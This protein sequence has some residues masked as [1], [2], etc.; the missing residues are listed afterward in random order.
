M[1]Q[2][3]P[4][5]SLVSMIDTPNYVCNS[6]HTLNIAI[7][8]SQSLVNKKAILGAFI[9]NH[10]PD[11]IIIS[12]TWLSSDISTAEIFP[13]GYNVFRRDRQG[14]HGGVLLATRTSL[15]CH[16]LTFN[17][18]IEA[19]S[20]K[21]TLKNNQSLIVCSVYRPPDRNLESMESLCQLFESLCSTHPDSP[22]WIAGD[23]N[24]PNIDWESFCITNSSYPANLCEILINFTLEHGFTQ[25]VNSPTRGK[26]ILDIF[27]TNRVSLV[28]HCST[29]AG[30]SDHEA[31]LV[32]SSL[33][34]NLEPP[35]HKI[36]LWPL[37]NI[38]SMKELASVL[39]Q[40]FLEKNSPS[41]NIEV[42][43]REFK[44]ICSECM[45]NVPSKLSNFKNR[46]QPWISHHIQQLSRKKQRLYNLAKSSQSPD[47]WQNYYKLKKEM[48]KSCRV[49]YND[50]VA[51]LVEDDHITKRLWTFIK[52]QRKDNCNIPP[53]Q[54]EG[55][56]YT[57]H[58]QKAEIFNNYFS[59]VFSTS[60]DTSPPTL[61]ES[62]IPDITPISIYSHGVKC[63]LD[64]LDIHKSAGPDNIPTRLLKELST[65]LAPILTVIFQ[66]SLLQ[67]CVPKEWKIAK[68]VPIYKKGDR[69]TPGNYRP[70]SLTSICCKLLE[71]IIYS[72]I[73]SHLNSHSI[74]CNEQHGFRQRRS[75][76]TQLLLTVQD[77]AKNLNEGLQTDVIFLDFSKAF[78]KVDH[79]CLIHKLNFYGIRGKLLSWLKD[80]LTDRYQSVIIEG[81]QSSTTKVTSGVPQGSVLAPLLFLCFINDLPENI[82]CKIKLYADDVLL[83]STIR[84]PNDCHQLQNDLITLEEWANKWRMIFNPSKCEYLKITNKIHPISTHYHIQ[85]HTIKEVSHAKYLGI[86]IDQHLTWNEHISYITTKANKVKCFLQR[87][88]KPCPTTVKTICYKSLIRSILDYASIIWSPH[89]QKNIQA[90]ESV[91]RRSARFVTNTYSPYASVT[92]LLTNLG[93]KPLSDRRNELRL[94]MF[95]KVVHHLV[96]INADNLLLPQSSTHTTR[97]HD[98]RF[99][100]QSTRVNAYLHSFFPNTI[101]L[102]NSLPH[103]VVHLT[104][105]TDFKDS[106]AGLHLSV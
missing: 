103:E 41:T 18:S 97:G 73:F 34:V 84:S 99:L 61:S 79:S 94:L 89:T 101:K 20:C 88:L 67:C 66:A 8:N 78:D 17:F 10:D 14:G 31:V 90:V 54:H 59:S 53:L 69:S 22:I 51:S 62:S 82:N 24:L 70:I 43:W 81:N 5:C 75:C 13:S 7:L 98:K 104:H 74:L 83:Y 35:S 93:W 106:I 48:H 26:N 77:L 4:Q 65:E 105:F 11:I 38:M 68:V 76:E 91:Q 45:K 50:Y 3:I 55:I 27:L 44:N 47:H 71:H 57:D 6:N 30:I 86:I 42:L 15:I 12:E 9:F 29:V 95:Y 49:A 36:Y 60:S 23:M 52:S 2:Q 1:I 46:K 80:F 92:N 58:L 63:L 100:Q 72:H 37:A 85:H 28:S 56:T 64:S 33:Q 40:V 19:V 87:N 39:C 16:E 96:D 102:W 21:L 25:V 32:K